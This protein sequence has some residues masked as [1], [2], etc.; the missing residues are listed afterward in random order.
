VAGYR[1][2]I[3]LAP[4]AAGSGV[5]PGQG[6]GQVN[7]APPFAEVLLMVD[8][9]LPHPGR[10]ALVMEQDESPN[11]A[12]IGFFGAKATMPGGIASRTRSRSL[13]GCVDCGCEGRTASCLTART[14]EES[15]LRAEYKTIL[16][17]FREVVKNFNW[18]PGQ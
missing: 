3:L 17:A 13:G 4:L 6:I 11:P 8:L 16:S 14:I 18:L 12:D 15:S 2:N 9:G 1:E 7:P 10:A 5:F